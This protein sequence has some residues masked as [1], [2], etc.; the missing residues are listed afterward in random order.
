MFNQ[1]YIDL[2]RE[3]ICL[4][5]MKNIAIG[6]DNDVVSVVALKDST[7]NEEDQENIPPNVNK[8]PCDGKQVMKPSLI[9]G[10]PPATNV[11]IDLPV[12]ATASNVTSAASCNSVISTNRGSTALA[13]VAR[14]NVHWPSNLEVCLYNTAEAPCE[15]RA[16]YTVNP[17]APT[18]LRPSTMRPIVEALKDST[19]NKV[20]QKSIPTVNNP[21]SAKPVI[22][23][24]S[25]HYFKFI[26]SK[27]MV[28]ADSMSWSLEYM[29]Y[30][31]TLHLSHKVCQ[32]ACRVQG[33]TKSANGNQWKTRLDMNSE[34]EIM[35][36]VP[37]FCKDESV[38]G[39]PMRTIFTIGPSYGK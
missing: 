13:T 10:I 25:N 12:T 6:F 38:N 26:T 27:K 9:Q 1:S 31:H 20:D 37:N 18:I 16:F 35:N 4:S 2:C 15:V 23:S 32:E 22:S 5:I 34:E 33:L 17:H 19:N 28:H 11:T 14:R 7:I 36:N 39:L 3:R 8:P 30:L 24:C 21:P 29:R